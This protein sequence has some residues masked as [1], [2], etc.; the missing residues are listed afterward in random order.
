MKRLLF[1]GLRL[2]SGNI[3]IGTPHSSGRVLN[4]AY[5]NGGASLLL[6]LTLAGL[7]FYAPCLL[8]A[9]SPSYVP[10]TRDT[11]TVLAQKLKQDLQDGSVRLADLHAIQLRLALKGV[12]TV[13]MSSDI[14]I[15][16]QRPKPDKNEPQFTAGLVPVAEKLIRDLDDPDPALAKRDSDQLAIQ[17]HKQYEIYLKKQVEAIK[18]GDSDLNRY[19]KLSDQLY[20]SL[21]KGDIATATVLA[22]E[23]QSAEDAVIAAKKDPLSRSKNVYNINDALG[24]AAFLRQDYTAASDYLLKAA[25]TPGKDPVLSTYGP[26]LWLARALST[27]G[28]KDVVITFLERCKAFWSS[29]HLDDWISTLQNGGSPDFSHNIWSAEPVLSH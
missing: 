23:V 2:A 24:R 15:L 5:P 11:V 1:S 7:A 13:K 29:P 17:I 8:S 4:G 27:A 22:V 6:T 25:D 9:Q 14:S 26:D 20:E 12:M 3:R 16:E 18:I 28:Y 19:I 10:V 21:R